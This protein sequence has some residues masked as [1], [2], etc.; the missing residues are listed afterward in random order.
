MLNQ[1][2]LDKIKDLKLTGMLEAW[3]AIVKDN[4][5]S[6]LTPTEFLGLM[7]DHEYIFRK[8][9]K[10]HRLLSN[11]KLRYKTAC[12]EGISKSNDKI[13]R[14]EI[15]LLRDL[16]WLKDHKNIILTGPTGVGKTYIA[17][18]AANLAC[19][20][21]YSSKYYK[22]SNLLELL[23]IA[24]ADGSYLNFMEKLCKFNC[25]II[26]DWGMESIHSARKSNILDIIDDFYQNGSL[27]ITSQLPVSSWHDY[28]DEP[29]IADA[30]LDRIVNNSIV[31][32]L[33]GDSLRKNLD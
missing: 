9:K 21:G 25:L 14:T 2:T 17:C 28:I 13:S 29:I 27:I 15:N 1:D 32:E 20:N 12:I 8:N 22:L 16:L 26:D 33:K 10:Q 23:K 11:A 6:S 30:I 5:H 7:I 24:N 31:I 3:N 4:E 18:A 19:R